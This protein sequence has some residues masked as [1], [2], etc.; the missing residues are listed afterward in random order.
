MPEIKRYQTK[1]IALEAYKEHEGDKYIL[2][3]HGGEQAAI[4]AALMER[5]F[6]SVPLVEAP[7]KMT[8][9]IVRE[10]IHGIGG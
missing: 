9:R 6:Y 2:I 5:L 4:D 10:E 7:E 8:R 1:N 3:F